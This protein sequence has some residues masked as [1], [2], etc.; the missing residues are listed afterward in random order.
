MIHD[1]VFER[2]RAAV[3]LQH[4]ADAGRP[5]DQVPLRKSLMGLDED[6]ARE[7]PAS[8][9]IADAPRF[10]S[11]R[12]WKLRVVAFDAVNVQKLTDLRLVVRSGMQHVPHGND[13]TG[14]E[15]PSGKKPRNFA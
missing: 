1:A 9:A 12:S 8:A 4:S 15:Q 6:I 11:R 3:A 10:C 2:R 5:A 13:V 14:G 7:D